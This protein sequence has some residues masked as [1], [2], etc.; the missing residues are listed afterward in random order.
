M[1]NIFGTKYPIVCAPMNQLSDSNLAVAVFN[2][3]CFPTFVLNRNSKF[4]STKFD[5]IKKFTDI[6]NNQNFSIL[7]DIFSLTEE[8]NISRL[9]K[10]NSKFIEI[11]TYGK[12]FDNNILDNT[13]V[14]YF[15]NYCRDNSIVLALRTHKVV[16]NNLE[17]F[18]II[19]IKGEES[20][21]LHNNRSIK[22]MFLEQQKVTPD[23]IICPSGGIATGKD[24]DWLLENGAGAVSIGTA[25]SLTKE[26]KMKINIKKK[27]LTSSSANLIEFNNRSAFFVGNYNNPYIN[28]KDE[29]KTLSLANGIANK[30]GHI[31]IGKAIDK[32]NEL[33]TVQELVN[34]LVSNSKYL[35][36]LT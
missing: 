17:Y 18:T 29:N 16:Y 23:K 21:G 1:N 31:F 13:K 15:L 2:A 20:A 19:N 7:A 6:T 11:G 28:D 8:N 12:G 30:S 32:V 27:I 9:I 25:F 36:C 4:D 33:L 3:G 5:E 26:S 22:E 10:Y 24:I 35:Q 34:N 14:K